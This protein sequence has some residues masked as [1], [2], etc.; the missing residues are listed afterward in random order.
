MTN[1]LKGFVTLL[2]L[3]LAITLLF[4]SVAVG[5]TDSYKIR[6]AHGLPATHQVGIQYAEWAKLVEE[7][8]NGQ[9]KVEIY[10]AGQLYPDDKLI[11]AVASGACEMGT[12]YT[13]NLATIVPAFEVF[14]IPFV[15]EDREAL[16]K[17]IEGDIGKELFTKVEDKGIKPLGWVVWAIGGEEM[18][19]ICDKPI[20]IPADLKGK[21]VRSMSPQQAQY[22]EEFCGAST[23]MVPGAEL[24][25]ALQRGTL[26]ASVATLSHLV[27]RKLHEV[28]PNICLIP[29]SSHPNIL[30]MNKNFYN[31][32]P[33][34]LQKV[35]N[36]VT[37]EI[38]KKSYE[39][40]ARVLHDYF[41]EC[42]EL[43]AGRGEIYTPTPEEYALWTKDIENFWKKVT[44]KYPEVYDLVLKIQNL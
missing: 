22:F 12:V 6:F 39:I 35:I 11:S 4:G 13:F 25:M 5:A 21:T 7:K 27:D 24:Y 14:I 29:I 40:S 38:Q 26:N 9:L 1:K 28:T 36:E 30:I 15:V 33:E 43:V 44:E 32:L 2:V 23:G 42:Q 20:H 41:I 16:L 18:G 34:D 8:S 10:P 31:N 17:I 37:A 3:V 19:V